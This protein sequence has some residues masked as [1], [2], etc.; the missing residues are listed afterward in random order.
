[1]ARRV[2]VRSCLSALLSVYDN[3]MLMLT[4]SYCSGGM[5]YLD[6]SKTFDEVDHG[7]LL[8]K[9][10]AMGIAGN[11]FFLQGRIY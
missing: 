1:M 9:R 5:I 6:F 11:F 2:S 10:R 4:E 8:H 3:L 7:V